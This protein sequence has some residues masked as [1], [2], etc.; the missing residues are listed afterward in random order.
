MSYISPLAD[1]SFLPSLSI[2]LTV[3]YTFLLAHWLFVSIMSHDLR[4]R[5]HSDQIKTLRKQFGLHGERQSSLSHL[6]EDFAL[7]G[8]FDQIYFIYIYKK[9]ELAI[10]CTTV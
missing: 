5:L 10:F 9:I 4:S 1:V 7:K 2:T 8:K 3:I 6:F